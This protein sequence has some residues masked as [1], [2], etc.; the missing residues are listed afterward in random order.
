MRFELGPAVWFDAV[1]HLDDQDPDAQVAVWH[2]GDGQDEVHHHHRDG[3]ERADR[4]GERAGVDA[5]VVL[6]GLHEPVG[7]DGQDGE[8]PHQH[9]VAHGVLV[10]EDLVV[11]EAVAD[12]AVA[13]DGDAGDVE[14]GADHTEANQEAAD[15]AVDAPGDPA[16]VEDGRQHKRV[17]VH[18]HQKVC[19]CQTHHKGISC[20]EIHVQ[21]WTQINIIK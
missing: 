12:V 18:S 4:L 5:R 16:V 9:Y 21:R 14:D 8:H 10:G 13:V 11:L 2:D 7:H 3:V 15:L 6:Q 1:A 19:Y 20:R 17:G